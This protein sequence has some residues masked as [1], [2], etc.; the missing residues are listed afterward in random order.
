MIPHKEETTSCLPSY[1]KFLYFL[2][3]ISIFDDF[4]VLFEYIVF[5][6]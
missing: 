2:N 1:V 4:P 3:I 5:A 6:I